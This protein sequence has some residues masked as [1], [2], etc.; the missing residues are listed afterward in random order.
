M[1]KED[2]LSRYVE[3]EKQLEAQIQRAYEMF[4]I[5]KYEDALELVKKAKNFCDETNNI[6]LTAMCNRL[7]GIIYITQG[8]VVDGI[9]KLNEA[10]SIFELNEKY[11]EVAKIYNSMASGFA[12]LSLHTQ[13]NM[14]HSQALAIATKINDKRVIGF[15]NLNIAEDYLNMNQPKNAELYLD[16][17]Y[18]KFAEIN[19][20]RMIPPCDYLQGVIFYEN[21]KYDKAKEMFDKAIT[22]AEK[23]NDAHTL[24]QIYEKYA[25]LNK[26]E[27]NLKEEQKNLDLAI[28]C[29]RKMNN[30]KKVMELM[31]RKQGYK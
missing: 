21:R 4:K 12:Q 1:K 27:N 2:M 11:A 8:N 23:T 10:L 24:S 28:I 15:L 9:K 25:N 22:G 16:N 18:K 31:E 29:Y 3:Y 19:E 7:E 26:A 30:H 13:A 14:Y 17:A 6:D 20:S 5:G